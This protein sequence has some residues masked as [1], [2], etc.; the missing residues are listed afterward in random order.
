MNSI[1]EIFNKELLFTIFICTVMIVINIT[2]VQNFALSN[3]ASFPSNIGLLEPYLC[4]DAYWANFNVTIP[5]EQWNI[6]NPPTTDTTTDTNTDDN[7]TTTQDN[8]T[9]TTTTDNSSTSDNNT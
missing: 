6:C 9:E 5:E 4:N 2:F 8:S 3:F 7:S 1:N